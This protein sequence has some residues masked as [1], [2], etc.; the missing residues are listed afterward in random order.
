[1]DNPG[2]RRTAIIEESRRES[3]VGAG[4]CLG[5]LLGYVHASTVG[6]TAAMVLFGAAV[7]ILAYQVWRDRRLLRRLRWRE[8]TDAGSS[9]SV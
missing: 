3:R 2:R 6:A 8:R 5:S 9:V 1:M 4:L 7:P